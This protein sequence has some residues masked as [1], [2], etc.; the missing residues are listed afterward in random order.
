MGPTIE[1]YGAHCRG[2]WGSHGEDLL[3]VVPDRRPVLSHPL[4]LSPCLSLSLS[5]ISPG[6]YGCSGPCLWMAWIVT[7]T[8]V[9]WIEINEIKI[10]SHM[11]EICLR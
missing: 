6:E 4:S 8:P 10:K 1:G 7:E 5:P 2:L 11:L 9:C 3:A